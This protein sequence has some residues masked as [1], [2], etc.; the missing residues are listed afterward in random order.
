MPVLCC[1]LPEEPDFLFLLSL[2]VC[3]THSIDILDKPTLYLLVM[4]T[5][6]GLSVL[7]FPLSQ[8][9]F[10][11]LCKYFCFGQVMYVTKEDIII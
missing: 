3:P 7:S 2:N 6:W 1:K 4:Y 11:N 10:S 8:S 9:N 5:Y